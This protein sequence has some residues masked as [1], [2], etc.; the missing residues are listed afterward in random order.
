MNGSFDASKVSF[1][2]ESSSILR[3]YR[4]KDLESCHAREK[5]EGEK[6]VSER[7]DY[8]RDPR[9]VNSDRPRLRCFSSR[10]LL[11]LEVI[12]G[13]DRKGKIRFEEVLKRLV[14]TREGS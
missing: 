4:V 6:K 5:K 9:K 8:L 7:L 11:A 12:E 1:G 13:L 3:L 2:L 14:Q 10:Y